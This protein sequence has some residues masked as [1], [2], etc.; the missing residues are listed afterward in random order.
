MPR[1]KI[2]PLPLSDISQ[3]VYEVI[4]RVHS[5][6]GAGPSYREIMAETGLKSKAAVGYHIERLEAVGW[7]TREPHIDRGIVPVKYPRVFYR[8]REEKGQG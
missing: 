2:V 1:Q 7:I 5:L 6:E 3:A 8:L 4:E